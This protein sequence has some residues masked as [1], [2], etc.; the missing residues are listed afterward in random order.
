M[1]TIVFAPVPL[2]CF[3]GLEGQ[4]NESAMARGLLLKL[5]IYAPI[6]D[7][8]CTPAA[9]ADEAKRN[10][11]GMHFLLCLPLLARLAAVRSQPAGQLFGKGIKLAWPI[12][13][14]KGWLD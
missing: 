9:R 10:K 14:G 7:K 3:A 5:S 13:D 6:P 11:I 12:W 8:G 1:E 2:E 4:R